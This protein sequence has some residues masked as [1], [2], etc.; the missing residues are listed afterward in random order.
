MTGEDLCALVGALLRDRRRFTLEDAERQ[1]DGS[2][3]AY[4]YDA[5][6]ALTYRVADGRAFRA[7]RADEDLPDAWIAP[8]APDRARD[9][10][11]RDA[12]ITL[13]ELGRI[14]RHDIT[15]GAA[16][17]ADKHGALRALHVRYADDGDDLYRIKVR[18][19]VGE[20]RALT[21]LDAYLAM[22]R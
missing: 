10:G 16:G 3:V 12:C 1:G 14:L 11:E 5:R 20:D 18:G 15:R 6:P 17:A 13:A 21:T 4:L 19:A 22:T 7:L 8:P 9:Y 2:W